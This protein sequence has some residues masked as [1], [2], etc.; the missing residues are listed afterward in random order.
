MRRRRLR[1]GRRLRRRTPFDE[2][3]PLEEATPWMRRQHRLMRRTSLEEATRRTPLDETTL[4]E[5]EEATLLEEAPLE[6][7]EATPRRR[8]PL[9]EGGPLEEAMAFDEEA[10][11]EEANALP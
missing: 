2:E 5:K 4:L 9:D 10:P 11:L 8:T 6:K 3:A 7:E 1:G